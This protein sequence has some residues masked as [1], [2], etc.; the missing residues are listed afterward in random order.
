MR[1]NDLQSSWA[2]MLNWEKRSTS[3]LSF[4]F[5]RNHDFPHWPF[6]HH[7]FLRLISQKICISTIP[8]FQ[9]TGKSSPDRIKFDF[10][11]DLRSLFA[12][13]FSSSQ[14]ANS[15]PTRT[16]HTIIVDLLNQC[17][18]NL[19]RRYLLSP[20]VILHPITINRE[21][22]PQS[23]FFSPRRFEFHVCFIALSSCCSCL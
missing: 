9:I 4:C 5:L 20:N 11:I 19:N 14:D 10:L 21:S 2:G 8:R 1:V 16:D 12:T 3:G 6:A 15:Q 23:R 13:G 7:E 22:S 17:M 18:T